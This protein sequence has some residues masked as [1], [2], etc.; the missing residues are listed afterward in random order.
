MIL[1]QTIC[2]LTFITSVLSLLL[3]VV[4]AQS[5]SKGKTSRIVIGT[6]KSVDA[7]GKKFDVL[8]NGE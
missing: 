1:K 7:S 6:L 4:Q 3:P 5:N 2:T 8:Q